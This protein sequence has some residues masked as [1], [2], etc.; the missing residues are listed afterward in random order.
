MSSVAN[1]WS[2]D[3]AET[4]RRLSAFFDQNRQSLSRFGATVNQTFE[5]FVFAS[6]IQWYRDRGW[7]VRLAN[8]KQ[9]DASD[10]IRLKF[11][12]RDAPDNYSYA[13]ATKGNESVQIRHQL[14]V[15]TKW[16]SNGRKPVASICLDLAIIRQSDL[17]T[18]RTDDAIPNTALVSF[19]EAKHMSAYAEL[20]A[21][22]IG[23]AHEIQPRR[24]AKRRGAQQKKLRKHGKHP[25]P[26]LFVSGVL[27]RSAK[28]LLETMQ[29][30]GLQLWVY[31]SADALSLRFG[32][33]DQDNVRKNVS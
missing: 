31:T 8:P 21:G 1:G 10:K 5:A 19:A 23:L 14:R 24:L 18:Y 3:Q 11:P 28:G 7:D 30:R 27:Y 32:L 26:F 33:R 20:V 17:S 13:T 2:F 4:Q 15:A 9:G 12:T 6:A 29:E 25:F 16:Y 22:F